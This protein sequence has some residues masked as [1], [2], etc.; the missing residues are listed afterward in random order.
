MVVID[1]EFVPLELLVISP[2]LLLALLVQQERQPV[3]QEVH[4]ATQVLFYN[5]ITN[6]ASYILCASEITICQVG[7]NECQTGI[8]FSNTTNTTNL[9]QKERELIRQEVHNVSIS[10][11]LSIDHM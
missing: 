9:V 8:T 11:I 1:V 5:N 7:S 2:M 3:T 4:S 6:T 10:G